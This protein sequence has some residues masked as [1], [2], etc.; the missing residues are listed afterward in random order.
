MQSV[1]GIFD[2]GALSTTPMPALS[3]HCS[4][5]NMART[6]DSV[7]RQER[8]RAMVAKEARSLEDEVIVIWKTKKSQVKGW[9]QPG[10]LKCHSYLIII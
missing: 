5:M 10:T 7:T 9:D 3:G 6:R 2:T 8:R 1:A 4:G